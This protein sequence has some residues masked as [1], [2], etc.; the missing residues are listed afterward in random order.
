MLTY[1]DYDTGRNRL[2]RR[3]RWGLAAFAL[4]LAAGY[5]L[6]HSL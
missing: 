5:L 3:Y 4:G 6:A 2:K 1:Y